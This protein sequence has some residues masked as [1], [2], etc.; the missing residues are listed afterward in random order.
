MTATW[1]AVRGTAEDAEMIDNR[2]ST[3]EYK[4]GNMVRS[5]SISKIIKM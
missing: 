3:I 4:E 5:N 1:T 2:I